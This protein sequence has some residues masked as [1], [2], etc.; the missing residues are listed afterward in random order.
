MATTQESIS[1]SG[2]QSSNPSQSLT[3]LEYLVL[4][5]QADTERGGAQRLKDHLTCAEEPVELQART[6][7]TEVG[8]ASADIAFQ[9]VDILR[10]DS[11]VMVRAQLTAGQLNHSAV[12][13]QEQIEV[14]GRAFS[15]CGPEVHTRLIIKD[16]SIRNRRHNDQ[17]FSDLVGM[18]FNIMPNVLWKLLSPWNVIDRSE[19]I[20][21]DNMSAP[22]YRVSGCPEVAQSGLLDTR[23]FRILWLGKTA[24]GSA[25]PYCGKHSCPMASS[26]TEWYFNSD[27]V[28]PVQYHFRMENAA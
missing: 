3:Y 18:G 7:N 23:R 21:S 12:D 8:K 4:F 22:L 10:D 26:R 2:N 27:L 9:I 14:F 24:V 17:L 13:S 20:E 5:L 28:V 1:A 19:D 6:G 25:D 11:S 15:N 16:A